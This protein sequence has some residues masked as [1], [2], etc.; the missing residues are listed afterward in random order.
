[1]GPEDEA[2]R[3]NLTST[4]PISVYCFIVKQV[5]IE[6]RLCNVRKRMDGTLI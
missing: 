2:L 6:T 4:P 1:M 3:N 5:F